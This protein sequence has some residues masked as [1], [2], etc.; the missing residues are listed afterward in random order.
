M[1]IHSVVVLDLLVRAHAK[2]VGFP[3]AQ[4]ALIEIVDTGQAL[5]ALHILAQILVIAS[6]SPPV[7][8]AASNISIAQS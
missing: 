3:A 4:S 8:A 6:L 7:A 5:I 2:Q 1:D